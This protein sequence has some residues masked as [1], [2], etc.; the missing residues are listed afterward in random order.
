[1]CVGGVG[2]GREEVKNRV[3]SPPHPQPLFGIE[4]LFPSVSSLIRTC[5][6]SLSP[7]PSFGERSPSVTRHSPAVGG[8]RRRKLCAW[9]AASQ[10]IDPLGRGRGWPSRLPEAARH[11]QLVWL[12]AAPGGTK[13]P[14]PPG[15]TDGQ[16]DGWREPERTAA[17]AE[18]S[19]PPSRRN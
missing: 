17:E 15:G 2:G 4:L 9:D 19:E 3:S 5:F 10:R 14:R 8:A 6:P 16:T 18:H 1:M 13:S 7:R 12:A 11:R